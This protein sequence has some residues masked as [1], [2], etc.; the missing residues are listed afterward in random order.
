MTFEFWM[1]LIV[2]S[3][4]RGDTYVHQLLLTACCT[5]LLHGH[6][7]QRNWALRLLPFTLFLFCRNYQ[8]PLGT[9]QEW[10]IIFFV[11]VD[12]AYLLQKRTISIS[13]Q[14]LRLR[15]WRGNTSKVASPDRYTW[16]DRTTVAAG[17]ESNLRALV[18]NF[19]S[20]CILHWSSTI[21]TVHCEYKNRH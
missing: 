11:N 9:Q 3:L 6:N 5:L 21:A 15:L 1:L 19:P 14:L 20:S 18:N 12:W 10:T 2:N 7:C 8:I 16:A 4:Q 17:F 13:W